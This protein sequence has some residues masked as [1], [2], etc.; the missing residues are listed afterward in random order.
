MWY[1]AIVVRHP[2]VGSLMSTAGDLVFGGEPTG[3]FNA[4]N[5][6]TGELLWQYQTG[7]GIHGSAISYNVRGKQYVAVTSGWGGWMKGFAPELYG[8][9]RGSALF[10]FALP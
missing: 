4:Y 8:A 9:N 1:P 7:S 3:E 2:M 10:V 5:A 6:R